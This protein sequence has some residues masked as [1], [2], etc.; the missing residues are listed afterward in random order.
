MACCPTPAKQES[1]PLPKDRDD[2]RIGRPALATIDVA[3]W[4]G[5]D[6]DPQHHRELA[7]H[8]LASCETASLQAQHVRLQI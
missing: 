2:Q 1:S 6:H 5:D 8:L 3:Q 7:R 4:N